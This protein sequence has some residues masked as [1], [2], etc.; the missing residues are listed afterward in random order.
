MATINKTKSDSYDISQLQTEINSSPDIVPS[1]T[2]ITGNGDQLSLEFADALTSEEDTALDSLV[3]E[4]T[5]NPQVIDTTQLPVTSLDN[6]KL[7]VY[8]SY[9]PEFEDKSLYAVWTGSGDDPDTGEINAGELMYFQMQQGESSVSKEIHF[10]KQHG[11]V[12]IHEGYLKFEDAGPGDYVDAYFIA[13]PTPTQESSDLDLV[14]DDDSWILPAPDGEGTGTHGFS[15]KQSIA[16]IPRTFSKD[17]SWDFDGTDV[18]PNTNQTGDYALSNVERNVH[19]FISNIPCLGSTST[20][21]MLSSNDTF[22]IPN[23]YFIRVI[24]YNES[25][26]TWSSSVLL[27]VYREKTFTP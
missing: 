8:A 21:T 7:S 19:K 2:S 16:L 20:F 5:P 6:K 22:E 9:K 27:E 11:R 24:F 12:W 17:G 10:S 3:A 1:C 14:I 23:N 4:H 26:T 25:D 15:D 13:K 18:I